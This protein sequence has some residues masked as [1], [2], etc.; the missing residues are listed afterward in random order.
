MYHLLA[1][2]DG[3]GSNSDTMTLYSEKYAVIIVLFQPVCFVSRCIH[4]YVCSVGVLFSMEVFIM[5]F[6]PN[7]CNK[8]NAIIEEPWQKV[9]IEKLR[10]SCGKA[11]EKLCKKVEKK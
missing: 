1:S 5:R 11:M 10:K 9:D 2:A 3:E 8:F 4:E 6:I 7:L